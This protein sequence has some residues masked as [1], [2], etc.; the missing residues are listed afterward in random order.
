MGARVNFK[1]RLIRAAGK[2]IS[3]DGI[4]RIRIRG[5]QRDNLRIVFCYC[6]RSGSGKR[7]ATIDNCRPRA[8]GRPGAVPFIVFRLH[9][10]LIRRAGSQSCQCNRGA[11][12]RVRL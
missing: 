5:S 7:R 12:A 4:T 9:L 10:H 11:G 3:S 2:F 6:L 8:R 1:Q